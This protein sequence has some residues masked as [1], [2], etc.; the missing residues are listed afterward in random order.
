MGLL[1]ILALA[2][3]YGLLFLAFRDRRHV[4]IVLVNL[5]LALI[6]VSP[7]WPCTAAS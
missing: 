2:G 5:P 7:R 4:A 1:S 3:M 6:G